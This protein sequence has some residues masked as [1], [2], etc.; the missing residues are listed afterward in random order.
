MLKAM[1]MRP[2]ALALVS[3]MMLMMLMPI[4]ARAQGP[5]SSGLTVPISVSDFT[6]T[7][8]INR[9]EQQGHG[10]VAIGTVVGTRADSPVVGVQ[11]VTVPVTQIGGEAAA[12][13]PAGAASAAVAQQA[14]SCNILSLVLGPLHL[15]LLGLVVDLNQVV[16]QIT[17]Q[18]G[19]GDLL[20]NLLCAVAGLLDPSGLLTGL[21]ANVLNQITTLL[22]RI[23]AAL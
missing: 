13:A 8:T 22:N 16:L 21:A 15:D 5:K 23:L 6:G 2:I 1:F 3:V 7:F 4:E 11:Q 20:G 18:T 17:G 9:F 14:A 19:A 10:V 12:T